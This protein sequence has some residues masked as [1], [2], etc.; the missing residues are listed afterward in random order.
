M[1]FTYFLNQTPGDFGQAQLD[2]KTRLVAGGWTVVASGDGTGGN[3]G[4]SSDVLTVST[5]GL[6][7]QANSI[8][9]RSAWFVIRDP[10]GVRELMFQHQPGGVGVDVQRIMYSALAKFAGT[11]HGAVSATIPPSA[12]DERLVLGGGHEP[13]DAGDTWAGSLGTGPQ[14]WDYAI[15]DAAEGYTFWALGRTS[16]GGVYNGGIFFDVVA[17]PPAGVPDPMVIGCIGINSNFLSGSIIFDGRTNWAVWEE[18]NISTHYVWGWP[19]APG[20]AEVTGMCQHHIPRLGG[21]DRD[22]I[23]KPLGN[24][25][26]D[27]LEDVVA[28]AF[29][30]SLAIADSFGPIVAPPGRIL[31]ESRVFTAIGSEASPNSMDTDTGLT[32]AYI[33][34]GLWIQWDG[35]TAPVL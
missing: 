34:G 30:A 18:T 4:P 31:G 2:M 11:K 33:L 29:W 25:P 23:H 21:F 10:G 13:N 14:R 16:P 6:D 7:A 12:A 15:G 22:E 32:R 35:S 5:P 3:F 28:P 1:A 27:G 19:G 20:G 26:Y 24:N 8:T 9:N 17:S